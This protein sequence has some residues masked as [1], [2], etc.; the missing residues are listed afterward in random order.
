MHHDLRLAA[1]HRLTDVARTLRVDRPGCSLADCLE[2]AMLH[3]PDDARLVRASLDDRE[4]RGLGYDPAS[5]EAI[6][7]AN[8]DQ[9]QRIRLFARGADGRVDRSKVV[10]LLAANSMWEDRYTTVSTPALLSAAITRL[11]SRS[12]CGRAVVW[13]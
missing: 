7:A 9:K 11:E 1:Q 4:A 8:A 3:A 13:P 12:S 5:A 2:L 6:R 10:A